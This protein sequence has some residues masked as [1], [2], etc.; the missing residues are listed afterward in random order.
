[1]NESPVCVLGD[2]IAVKALLMYVR[3]SL[4]G[5]AHPVASLTALA[6]FSGGCRLR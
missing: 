4:L 2:E 3:V 5:G 6:S 1:M